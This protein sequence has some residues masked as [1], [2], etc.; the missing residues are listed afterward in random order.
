LGNNR[1]KVTSSQNS[2]LQVG[3]EFETASFLTGYPLYLS[4]I[5]RNGKKTEAYVAGRDGGIMLMA[6]A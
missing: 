3:D 4:G 2:H 1:F 6:K 5:Y